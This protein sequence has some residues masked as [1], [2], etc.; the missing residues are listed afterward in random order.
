MVN[1]CPILIWLRRVD[2]FYNNEKIAGHNLSRHWQPR[3]TERSRWTSVRLTEIGLPEISERPNPFQ[4]SDGYFLFALFPSQDTFPFV[5]FVLLLE[6]FFFALLLSFIMFNI[7]SLTHTFEALF[8]KYIKY[9]G[10]SRFFIFSI[11]FWIRTMISR[12]IWKNKFIYFK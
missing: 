6:K 12:L 1:T 5:L 2:M 4:F 8:W 10:M 7:W 11:K 9:S 3:K